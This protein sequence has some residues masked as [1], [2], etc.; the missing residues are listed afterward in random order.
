VL[1]EGPS[2][3]GPNRFEGRH[4]LITFR[5]ESGRVVRIRSSAA[6]LN[7]IAYGSVA[8]P[9]RGPWSTEMKIGNVIQ[10]TPDNS[11]PIHVGIGLTQTI[12]SADQT[13]PK[14]AVPDAGSFP[15]AWV[16]SLGAIGSGLAVL[17]MRRRGHWGAA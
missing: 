4:A 15:W 7:G 1:P 3:G 2:S 17:L 12:P 8:F 16:L 5:S 10:T 14:P 11:E 13:T 9:D 6:D